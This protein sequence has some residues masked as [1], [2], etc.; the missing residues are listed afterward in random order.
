MNKNHR[1]IDMHSQW[2]GKSLIRT[3][4]SKYGKKNKIVVEVTE[5]SEVATSK[6]RALKAATEAARRVGCTSVDCNNLSDQE[7]VRESRN[8]HTDKLCRT[9]I[10]SMTFAFD[11]IE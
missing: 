3:V 7:I 10:R 5:I 6:L 1:V 9:R 4:T 8:L 11:G 2:V